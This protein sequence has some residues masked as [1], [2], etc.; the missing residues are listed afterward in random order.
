MLVFVHFLVFGFAAKSSLYF[1]PACRNRTKTPDQ[2]NSEKGKNVFKTTAPTGS[3]FHQGNN[4]KGKDKIVYK[5]K[6]EENITE[7]NITK[8]IGLKIEKN[9]KSRG[10]SEGEP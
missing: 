4:K 2:L 6:L 3:E 5:E 1:C 10:E 7:N 9:Q 8:E